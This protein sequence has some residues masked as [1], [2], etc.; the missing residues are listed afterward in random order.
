MA[1]RDRDGDDDL[2]VANDDLNG[3]PN[4]LVTNE[5]GR[6]FRDRAAATGTGLSRSSMGAAAGDVDG[7]ARFDLAISDIGREALLRADGA[8]SFEEVSADAGFGR[9]AVSG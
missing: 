8:F 4:A 7:D 1:G 5:D 3:R 9:E 2:Y 6:G